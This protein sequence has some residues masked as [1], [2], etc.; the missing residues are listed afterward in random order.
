M[1]II[2]WLLF[3]MAADFAIAG[4]LSLQTY[5]DHY[6]TPFQALQWLLGGNLTKTTAAAWPFKQESV[7]GMLGLSSWLSPLGGTTEAAEKAAGAA[8]NAGGDVWKDLRGLF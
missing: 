4:G 3:G 8:E 2:G 1:L 5:P 7:A 6:V